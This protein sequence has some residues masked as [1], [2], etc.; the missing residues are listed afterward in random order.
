[1]PTLERFVSQPSV[2]EDDRIVCDSVEV[3]AIS[4]F[5]YSSVKVALNGVEYA[6]PQFLRFYDQPSLRLLKRPPLW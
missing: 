6:E 2:L 4:P 1:M 3:D 5:F